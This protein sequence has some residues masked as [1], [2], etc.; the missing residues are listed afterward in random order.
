[1]GQTGPTYDHNAHYNTTHNSF[2]ICHNLSMDCS[3]LYAEKTSH[4]P[5]VPSTNGVSQA[6]AHLFQQSNDIQQLE[7]VI[8]NSRHTKRYL[9]DNFCT[10]VHLWHVPSTK[11]TQRNGDLKTF[12]VEANILELSIYFHDIELFG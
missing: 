5:T 8:T 1:M 3:T 10:C 2:E 11:T 6:D 12:R 7:Q 9:C 4:V